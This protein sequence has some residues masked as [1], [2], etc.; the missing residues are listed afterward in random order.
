MVTGGVQ[1]QDRE[2]LPSPGGGIRLRDSRTGRNH[3]AASKVAT[4]LVTD[5]RGVCGPG[6]IIME[7]CSA[8]VALKQGQ[9]ASLVLKEDFNLSD[10]EV[11]HGRQ[12]RPGNPSGSRGTSPSLRPIERQREDGLLDQAKRRDGVTDLAPSNLQWM[13]PLP[14]LSPRLGLGVHGRYGAGV[15][16]R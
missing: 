4:Q 6:R 11:H 8:Q 3:D 15:H 13:A 12:D 14:R 9:A 10:A 5:L 7:S 1:P 16:T 2:T